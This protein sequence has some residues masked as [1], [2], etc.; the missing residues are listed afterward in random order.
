VGEDAQRPVAVC[1]K[2]GV[3]NKK[4]EQPHNTVNRGGHHHTTGYKAQT[5]AITGLGWTGTLPPGVTQAK[6]ATGMVWVLGRV[7]CTGTPEDYKASPKMGRRD[8]SG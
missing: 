2:S 7:Y 3:T 4:S 1:S 5:Y 6:S 8:S